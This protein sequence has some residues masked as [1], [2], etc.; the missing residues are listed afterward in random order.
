M[1]ISALIIQGEQTIKDVENNFASLSEAELN[2]K[3][4][5]EKWSIAQCLSHLIEVNSTYFDDF[6]QI[7]AGK[8]TPSFW[9]KYSPFSNFFGKFLIDS[10]DPVKIKPIKV[11]AAVWQPSQSQISK[12]IVMQF[13]QNQQRVLDKMRIMG[14]LP[15]DKIKIASPANAFLTYSLSAAFEIMILHGQR[16]VNQAKK[17]KD[18][19]NGS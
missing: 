4:N 8:Y 1:T 3:Q 6:E 9:T 18:A 17:V 12:Q 15:M 5:P 11:P 14:N 19:Q 16:H 10:V 7:I 2:W 13:I